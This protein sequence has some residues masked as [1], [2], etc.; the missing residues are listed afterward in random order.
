MGESKRRKEQLGEKYGQAE[1]ILPGLP[2][3][4]EQ[5]RQFVKWTTRGTWGAI[6]VVIA[7][8]IT[9]RFVGPG[10]GWWSLAD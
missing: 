3:T 9:L 6:I 10:L 8:W 5:S 1:P 2:I 7:F 4:K